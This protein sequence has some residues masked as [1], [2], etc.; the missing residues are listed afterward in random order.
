MSTS[1]FDNTKIVGI[2]FLVVGFMLLIDAVLGIILGFVDVSDDMKD[3]IKEWTLYCVIGGIG[4]CICATLYTIFAM[5]VYKGIFSEKIV[6]LEKYVLIVGI[7]T[8]IG[9]I[10]AGIATAVGGGDMAVALTAVILSVLIGALIIWIATQIND[11]KKTL[12][13]KVIWIILMVAFVILLII[14][15]LSLFSLAGI[16]DGIAHIIIALFM[17]AFLVDPEVRSKMNM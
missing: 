12:A 5:K 16:V 8:L 9:G 6:I 4:S 1:F 7:T 15:V 17:I 13:D 11:D 3:G 14:G 10:F 2:A